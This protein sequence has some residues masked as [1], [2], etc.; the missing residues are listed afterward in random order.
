MAVETLDHDAREA[1]ESERALLGALMRDS[2][3]AWPQVKD[4]VT[5]YHFARPDHRKIFEAIVAQIAETGD[6]DPFLVIDRLGPAQLEAAGGRQY[7]AELHGEAMSAASAGS[8]AKKIREFAGRGKVI[9]IAARLT[10]RARQGSTEEAAAFVATEL[11]RL[12]RDFG[13]AADPLTIPP[14]AAWAGKPAPQPREWVLDGMIPA[15]RVTSLFGNGGLGKTLLAIQIGLH[16]SLG[17]PLF[18]VPVTGG[19]VLG[20]FCEDEDA[21]INRRLRAACAA[22]RFELGDVDRFFAL[23]RDGDDSVLCTFEHDHIK[24]TSFYSQLEAT[25]AVLR[26]HLVILDTAADL[27]AGDFLS[28]PHVR[29]F[30][31]IALGGLCVRHGCAVLLLAHPSAAAMTSGEGGG[32]ST[33]WSNS[34]RSRLYLSRPKAPTDTEEVVD[35]HDRRVLEV[36]KSNY[37]AG[38]VK[39][40][41]LYQDGILVP[42]RDLFGVAPSGPRTKTARVALAAL[43]YIRSKSPLVVAFRD[44]F[45]TLQTAGVIP[46][47]SYDEHR[48]PLNRALVQLVADGTVIE[49]RT[50]RGYRLNPELK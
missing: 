41:L 35:T 12:K 43:D 48:K 5:A 39:I 11:E 18:E 33:A 17:R 20:I 47:G 36:K 1:A 19:P 7:I 44:L 38:D 30:L 34:V 26:P 40:P 46:P 6:A 3:R 21:E 2:V 32:F 27:F 42:D 50:P 25:V 16:V 10:A 14:A 15:G 37:A 22:E 45:S 13:G 49:T 31:K 28:T 24:L 9:D 23:S 29:Q 8:Y 4:V